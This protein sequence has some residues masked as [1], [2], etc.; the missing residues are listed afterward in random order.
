LS[1]YRLFFKTLRH[2]AGTKPVGAS[3]GRTFVLP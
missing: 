1:V 2:A 3:S